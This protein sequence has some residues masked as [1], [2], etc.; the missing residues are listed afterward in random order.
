MTSY[1]ILNI[2]NEQTIRNKAKLKPDGV[3]TLRGIIY[4]VKGGFPTHYAMLGVISENCGNFLV[5]VGKYEYES[6][7]KKIL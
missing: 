6:D 3:Y 4:R 1:G 7:A 5:D 2:D